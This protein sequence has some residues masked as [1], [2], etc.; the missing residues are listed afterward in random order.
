M[1]PTRPSTYSVTYIMQD[2]AH[3]PRFQ[4]IA[5]APSVPS[6][7]ALAAPP[8]L[9]T[10]APLL[11]VRGEL[12]EEPGT[13]LV[14]TVRLPDWLSPRE[15]MRSFDLYYRVWAL[16]ANWRWPE[17][18]LRTL[19]YDP[20]RRHAVMHHLVW[21]E[22]LKART[23]SSRLRAS[24]HRQLWYWLDRDS[25]LRPSTPF[26]PDQWRG[27]LS[28]R[29]Q[30]DADLISEDLAHAT[31]HLPLGGIPQRAVLPAAAVPAPL[32]RLPVPGRPASRYRT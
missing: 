23:H 1:S 11:A 15:W 22:L 3:L 27:L 28:R 25:A 6:T 8:E 16:G 7:L 31:E 26:T 2:S 10:S 5:I 20:E 13:Q 9:A 32:V 29:V 21:V 24:L 17:H 14:R 4:P 18:W 19:A 12:P 30:H